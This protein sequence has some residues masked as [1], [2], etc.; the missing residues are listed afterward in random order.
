MLFIKQYQRSIPEHMLSFN[1]Y[2]NQLM[3]RKI[4]LKVDKS[5]I[6]NCPIKYPYNFFGE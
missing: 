5:A 4:I 3:R 1:F 6:K 2:K